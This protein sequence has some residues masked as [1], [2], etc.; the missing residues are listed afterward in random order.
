MWPIEPLPTSVGRTLQMLIVTA[1]E[2]QM[3]KIPYIAKDL[4]CTVCMCAVKHIH[5]HHTLTY[6]CNHQSNE[7]ADQRVYFP[8]VN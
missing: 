5:L 4:D 7:L 6:L 8:L 2:N 3:Y 1:I